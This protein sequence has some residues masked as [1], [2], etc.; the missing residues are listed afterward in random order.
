MLSISD[1]DVNLCLIMV[2]K[3]RNYVIC[4]VYAR[5]VLICKHMSSYDKNFINSNFFKICFKLHYYSLYTTV[6]LFLNDFSSCCEVFFPSLLIAQH[7]QQI[8]FHLQQFGKLLDSLHSFT[9]FF[10]LYCNWW[11]KSQHNH[12]VFIRYCKI[13]LFVV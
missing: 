13:L 9:V 8:Q 12:F 1:I 7:Q 11:W 3:F 5:T 10:T 4:C 2:N 6:L